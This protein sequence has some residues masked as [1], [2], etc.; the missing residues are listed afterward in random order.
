MN[1]SKLLAKYHSKAKDSFKTKLN[2]FAFN[3]H[4]QDQKDPVKDADFKNFIITDAIIEIYTAVYWN[5]LDIHVSLNEIEGMAEH[6]VKTNLTIEEL[7]KEMKR[8]IDGNNDQINQFQQEYL[9]D[10][11]LIFPFPDFEKMFE[12]PHCH[13][14]KITEDQIAELIGKRKIFNKTLRG[15][16]LEIDRKKANYEYTPDNSVLSCYWCNNAKTDEF[17]E[18]EFKVIGEEIGKIWRKRLNIA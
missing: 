2:L 6:G 18:E 1:K 15:F 9:K 4:I 12:N 13:Y 11:E 8:W 17:S 14:C 16:S 10:F 5:Y 3:Y 7:Y